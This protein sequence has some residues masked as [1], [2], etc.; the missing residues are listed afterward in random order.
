MFVSTDLGE[1]SEAMRAMDRVVD[2]RGE[3]ADERSLVDE[4]VLEIL[5]NAVIDGTKDAKD[6]PGEFVTFR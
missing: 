1:F 3:K 2:I 6:V 5:V 4:E